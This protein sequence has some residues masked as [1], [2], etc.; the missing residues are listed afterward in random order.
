[1]SDK[2]MEV[3]SIL[4]KSLDSIAREA[5]S[6]QDMNEKYKEIPMLNK[7]LDEFITPKEASELI[8]IP[9]QRLRGLAKINTDFPAVY[10]GNRMYIIKSKLYDFFY[11]NIGIKM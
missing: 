6:Q 7:D 8:G 1:M 4:Q 10:C 2:S 9:A 5:K 11:N 3:I